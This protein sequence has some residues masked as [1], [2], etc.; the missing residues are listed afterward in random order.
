MIFL[1]RPEIVKNIL[2]ES[3][4][5]KIGKKFFIRDFNISSRGE[6]ELAIHYTFSYSM[7]P[8]KNK[9]KFYKC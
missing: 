3:H 9:N 7:L 6:H 4:L 8:K 5:F 1:K 2:G